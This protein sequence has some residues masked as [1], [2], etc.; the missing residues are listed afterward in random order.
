MA[1]VGVYTVAG[2]RVGL[3]KDESSGSEKG[4]AW[5]EGLRCGSIG[6]ISE[7]GSGWSKPYQVVVGSVGVIFWEGNVDSQGHAVGK[8]GQQDEDVEGPQVDTVKDPC[9]AASEPPHFLGALTTQC[10]PLIPRSPALTFPAPALTKALIVTH[11]P[12]KT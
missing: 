7:R 1:G 6:S 10:S 5:L 9:K 12:R 8:D 11:P 4:G 2:R 3:G